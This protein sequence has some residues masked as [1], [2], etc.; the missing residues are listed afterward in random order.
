MA[1]HSPTV[2]RRQLSMALLELRKQRG[3]TA[4]EV[5]KRLDW[6]PSKL[7]RIE[8]NDWK[9]PNP[10]DIRDLLDAY[11]VRDEAEREALIDLAKQARQ[12][13]WWADC[14]DV[15]RGRLPAF[16]AGARVLRTF[17]HNIPGLL[18]GPDYMRAIF[19]AGSDLNE[20]AIERHV[21]ARLARQ[22]ILERDDPPQL[23]TVIDEAA[24]HRL[25]GGPDVMQ[26]QLEH[27]IKMGERPNVTIQVLP[28]TAGAHEALAGGFVILD[29]ESDGASSLVYTETPT[30][31]IY[32]EKPPDVHR[33]T[34]IFGTVQAQA[35]SAEESAQRVQSRI[36]DLQKR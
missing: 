2:K 23:M 6:T 20:A 24:L 25:I 32:R 19:G 22:E 26:A 36:R 1:D 7:T 11:D 4:A 18:Q 8:R 13:G 29:F 16:E 5:T 35:L 31:D 30:D 34:V 27:L 14:K 12:R 9:L 17:D 21:E 10:R 3:L 28:F 15:F 33:Y